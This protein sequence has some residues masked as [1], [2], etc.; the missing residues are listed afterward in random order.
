ME[1]IGSN[2]AAALNLIFVNGVTSNIR[3]IRDTYIDSNFVMIL[4]EDMRVS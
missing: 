4:V 1:E 2:L 3:V